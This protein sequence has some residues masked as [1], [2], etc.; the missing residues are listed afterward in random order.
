MNDAN[1]TRI[2][3][4]KSQVKALKSILGFW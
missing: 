1:K 4:S 2:S 3:V